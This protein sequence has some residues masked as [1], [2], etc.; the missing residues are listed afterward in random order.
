MRF[1]TITKHCWIEPRHS[2]TS[3]P[4]GCCCCIARPHEQITFF[5]WCLLSRSAATLPLALGGLGLRSAL[6]TRSSA[7]WASWADCL[8]MFF[9]RYRDL[10]TDF[11]DQLEG[12]PEAE[13]LRCAA[14]AARRLDGVQGF[15]IP[16]WRALMEGARPPPRDPEDDEPGSQRQ[17]WQH[18]ASSRI[19]RE[20][21][22]A[23]LFP[24]INDAQRA[25]LRSQSGP[26]AGVFLRTTPCNPV[27]R[28]DSFTF[29]ILL[30]RR[31]GFAVER[32]VARVCREGGARVSTNIMVRDMDLAVP[33]PGDSRRIEVLADGLALFGGVQL[34]IDTTLVSP[35]HADGT[36]RPGAAR[37]DGVALRVARRR[38]ERRYPE[39][40]G[41]NNRCRLVVL[42]GE[43]G[44][45]WSDETRTLE[46][47]L[48]R[49]R[50]EQAWRLR[51]WSLLSCAAARASACS[52]VDL[53]VPGGADGNLPLAC[54]VE[55]EQRCAGLV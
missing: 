34:A 10:V 47:P 12:V 20:F 8:S 43:V 36:A 13:H 7:F 3:S 32:V 21:R 54:E 27:T 24:T 1:N 6:R 41:H 16:S 51:W 2:Q 53:R 49:K 18:E 23:Q 4:V 22:D 40:S 9:K 11:V 52:L 33:I 35:L 31:L 39:L 29:R 14:L 50:V 45:R 19:E 46:P 26:G 30:C 17:G 15:E 42:A 38:K 55:G 28:L 44:G 5:A 48:L 25:L 37:N